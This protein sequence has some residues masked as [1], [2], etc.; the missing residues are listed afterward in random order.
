LKQSDTHNTNLFYVLVG[1]SF[2]NI[3]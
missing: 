1:D 3:K 2:M